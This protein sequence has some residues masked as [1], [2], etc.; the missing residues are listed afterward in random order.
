MSLADTRAGREDA[1]GG[2]PIGAALL[3]Q[4]LTPELDDVGEPVEG[5]DPLPMT[6]CMNSTSPQRDATDA[7]HPFLE[8]SN[9]R[10]TNSANP[11]AGQRRSTSS[12]SHPP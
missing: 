3:T 4:G 9:G 5:H 11:Y 1:A 7:E 2:R 8:V 12:R 6:V 10:S